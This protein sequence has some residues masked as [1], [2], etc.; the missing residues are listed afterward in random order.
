MR[1]AP[2]EPRRTSATVH[3][4][5]FNR[6]FYPDGAATGQL[7]TDLAEDL[8]RHHGWRVTVITG[9]PLAPSQAPLPRLGG[10]LVARETYRGVNI[11]RGWGTRFDKSRFA[12]RAANYLTYFAT[13]CW[14]GLRVDRPDVVVAMTDPP[15]IGLAGWLAAKRAGAPLVMAYQDLFPEVTAL[16]EDFHSDVVD[17]G[18]QGVNRFLC[19]RAT[20]VI[21]LGETM[22][23]RLIEN[24]GARES[25]TVVISNWADTTAIVPGDK[26]NAFAREHGLAD[27]FVVMHSGNLGLSQ[28]LETIVEAAALLRDLPDVRVV[29]QGD[30]VKKLDLERQAA[31]LGLTNV[32]FL[33]YAP[34]ARLGETF[35]VADV[36]IVSLQRGLAGYIVPSKL[37]GILAAGRPYVAAVE[38]SCEVAAIT[39]ARQCGLVAEPG[40]AASLARRLRELYDDRALTRRLG[41]NARAAGLLFDRAVQVGR[42]ASL[43]EIV[44]RP[45]ASEAPQPATG[46]A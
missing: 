30:G 8:V 28:N 45:R 22:R 20:R 12:G 29:F 19:R 6:S 17:R 23:R 37:Y 36:F 40:D 35:A 25:Q 5:F 43:L 3:V 10:W 2:S 14:A 11:L 38:E 7:L 32:V 15:I 41:A 44:T 34:K 24:K 46:R 27:A 9:A 13:A 18:L 21:A 33:P 31:A 26:H 39:R 1:S 16:L 4:V 42:Y